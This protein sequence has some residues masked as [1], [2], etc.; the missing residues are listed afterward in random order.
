MLLEQINEQYCS[1]SITKNTEVKLDPGN[2]S[3][4]ICA[5]KVSQ[6]K[7][8]FWYARLD[9]MVEDNIKFQ[10]EVITKFYSL[11]GD[12]PQIK[13]L[14]QDLN[15]IKIDAEL[16]NSSIQKSLENAVG[17]RV[18]INCYLNKDWTNYNI[19]GLVDSGNSDK[20]SKF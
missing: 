9:F 4:K 15:L 5:A 8:N 2:Y 11:E 1:E 13:R 6:N 10:G 18:L 3:V 7:N 19:K 14:K 16:L 20:D 12:K 17:K